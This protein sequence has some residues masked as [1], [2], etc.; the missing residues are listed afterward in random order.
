MRAGAVTHAFNMDQRLVGLAFTSA[1]GALTVTAPANAN[2]APPGWYL[3]FIL[4]KNGV[5]SIGKFVH[6]GS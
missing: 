6:I 4:D 1:S 3:V 2:L 5:P